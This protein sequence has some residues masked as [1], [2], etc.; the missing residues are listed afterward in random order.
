MT[1][2]VERSSGVTILGGGS[3]SRESV[4]QALR[5]APHLV[6][7]DGA[8]GTA[9]AMGLT[10]EAVIGDFD[11]VSPEVLARIPPERQF[12]MPEQVTTDFDKCLRSIAAPLVLGVGFMGQRLD[13]EL[14]CYNSLVRLADSPC[15]LV[16]EHDI[17]FH[18]GAGADLDLPS[19]TRISL[20]PMA[21]VTGSAR[22]LLWPIEGLTFAPSGRVGTSNEATGRVRLDFA[23]PGML[24]ILPRSALG[25]A[26]AALTRK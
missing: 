6:A 20:F 4:E 25:A 8:A 14:A 26:A 19:G 23:G 2:I 9:L 11:S 18:A 12:R 13:H 22:G 5:L 10:P 21:E 7:A 15:L 1:K 17:C 16:G 24:V 3:L